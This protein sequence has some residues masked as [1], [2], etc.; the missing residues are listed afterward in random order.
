MLAGNESAD[1]TIPA[2]AKRREV[3]GVLIVDKPSGPTSFDVVA[4][5]RK[6]YGTKSV[7]HAGTLDPLATGVLVVMLGEATKLSDYLTAAQKRY[8]A[9]ITFG[10]STDTFDV[11]GTK[12]H[13]RLVAPEEVALPRVEAALALERARTEQVPPAYSAIKLAGET[14]YK[15]ARRGEVVE[16]PPRPVTVTDLTI[17]SLTPNTLTLAM[18]VSKGY[19]VRS[20]VKDV[21]QSLGV[22]GCLTA[23][24][25]TASGDFGIEQALTWP[26][27]D[28]TRPCLLSLGDAARTALPSGMLTPEGA[29]RAR[30]GKRLTPNDFSDVP[31]ASPAVWTDSSGA[32]VAIGE[33][34]SNA[35][36]T[37]F[38][39]LR[40]FKAS[41]PDAE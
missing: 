25:R 18:T 7:G 1:V 13:T 3:T 40:G 20:L 17:D 39:V 21:C 31:S 27:P 32:P 38:R 35:D 2:R 8:L 19:Y 28:G 5:V 9:T 36:E 15:K 22:P 34:Y 24:R 11:L 10:S 16:L 14:A 4:Q 37:E 30:H 29:V 33:S 6:R 26:P 41:S 12:V 23:L